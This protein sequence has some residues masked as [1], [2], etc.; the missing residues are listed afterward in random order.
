MIDCNMKKKKNTDAGEDDIE[1]K[2]EEN[3]DKQMNLVAYPD[4]L[5]FK[6][7]FESDK[8]WFNILRNLNFII[9]LIIIIYNY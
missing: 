4:S 7:E 2:Q 6:I 1:K 3:K 9:F 8:L 5:K